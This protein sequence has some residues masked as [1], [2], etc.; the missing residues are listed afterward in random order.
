MSFLD[1]NN[2]EYLSARLTQKGRNAIAKGDFVITNFAIGDSEFVYTDPFSGITSSVT[3]GSTHQ[4]VFAPL[5]KD[6]QVKYPFKMDSVEL[7]GTTIYGVPVQAAEVEIVRNEMGAAGFVG[8]WESTGASVTG[9]TNDVTFT[10]LS[11]TTQI[12]VT[13]TTGTTYGDCDT[14]TLVFDNISGTT[15]TIT[16]NTNSF[17]YKLISVSGLT[18]TTEL[19]TLDR[20]LPNLSALTGTPYLIC[21]NCDVEF[22]YSSDIDNT[23]VITGTTNHTVPYI[24][25][26]PASD[27]R[28]NP[29]TL[30]VVWE[31]KP[32]GFDVS[33]ADES[34]S[35]FT[36][37]KYIS[38]KELLGYSSTG[39]TFTDYS[40][41][42]ISKPT[43]Y[44][45]SFDEVIEVLP[46]EQKCIAIIHYSEVGD[47]VNDPDRFFK[48]DD[49]ISDDVS[50]TNTIT[51]NRNDV[52]ISDN[53][54][55]E[56]YIP[57]LQYH[58]NTGST[59][60]AIFYMVG[61]EYGYKY[62]VSAKNDRMKIKY[63]DLSDEQ[64]YK[65]GKV[66]V[67][68]K[69]IVFDD[70]EIVATLDLKSNRKYTLPAPKLGLTPSN[71][72]NYALSGTTNT[73]WVT[74]AFGY[75]T[76]RK[77]SGLPCNYFGKIQGTSTASNVTFKFDNEF[78]NMKTT[79]AGVKTGFIAN[80]FHIL[81]QV[82]T[83]G[84]LPSPNDWVKMD[85]T[86]TLNGAGLIN[87]STLT[88]TTFTIDFDAFDTYS[89][90]F[91]LT[92]HLDDDFTTS[93]TAQF[94][95]EQP[96]PGSVRLVRASDIETMKFLVNLPTGKFSSSQNPTYSSGNA[97][98]TEVAL[99][100]SN[101]EAL[102]I[103]K[104]AKPITRSGTQVFAVKLDF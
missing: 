28:H 14:V 4:T 18:S 64:G 36:S 26:L 78:S 68:K 42:T 67:D 50:E 9:V 85:F 19:L 59:I 88:G 5:D 49:Y 23:C 58:R 17:V 8:Q 81:A 53:E 21:N 94:G 80:E 41:T 66:F 55:F 37:N 100:N 89:T 84:D 76:D 25:E 77:L 56:V 51:L 74:Y 48:Y 92:D 101:K 72:G 27:A 24:P 46:E 102:V 91:D 7:S 97:K 71:D 22:P 2:S 86:T 82:T 83:T 13:K 1:K 87:P 90:A 45:N 40:G 96:F 38:T 98:I 75:S 12:V 69:I 70:Q 6:V 35:G 31:Q 57:F 65:V 73:M 15:Q 47:I 95:E 30:N 39:Q 104:T 34:L 61:G 10:Q 54:F 79:V 43:S 93:G 44:L 3:T 62:M 99:L 52:E 33:V 60:G 20:E 11:G 16:G 63:R 29:W 32:I 103:A